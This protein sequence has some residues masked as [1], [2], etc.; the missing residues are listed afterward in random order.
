MFSMKKGNDQDSYANN[1]DAQ[2]PKEVLDTGSR[3]YNKGWVFVHG[4]SEATGVAYKQQF[5]SDLSRF[6][7][8]RAHEMKHGSVM[9]LVCMG[10][11]S[12]D[13]TDQ[14]G[15]GVIIGTHFQDAWEDLV[16]EGL[17]ESEKRDKFNIPF[18]APTVEE[19]KEAVEANGSYHLN[20]LELNVLKP[21]IFNWPDDKRM[22]AKLL[23]GF[24]RMLIEELVKSYIGQELTNELFVRMERR[25]INGDKIPE[26]NL[27]YYS[28]VCSLSFP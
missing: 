28:L 21:S 25:A 26:E 15:L 7:E 10:R 12:A 2:V 14:A 19:F 6:L 9:Y 5:K 3:A 17:I 23:T 16:R 27:S 18:Y 22:V 24:C 4:A 20:K 1:S 11:V 13:P 8:A